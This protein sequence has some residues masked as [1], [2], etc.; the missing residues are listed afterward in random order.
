MQQL[1][2]VLVRYPLTFSACCINC[3]CP[4]AGGGFQLAVV[5]SRELANKRPPPQVTYFVTA[6]TDSWL[7]AA[8]LNALRMSAGLFSRVDLQDLADFAPEIAAYHDTLT[9][10]TADAAARKQHPNQ[11]QQQQPQPQGKDP[12]DACPLDDAA[13]AAGGG[14]GTTESERGQGSRKWET[15]P[16]FVSGG[17][18]HPYQLEGL[19]WLYHKARVKENVILADEMGLGKTIQA[20]AYLGALWQVCVC[21]CVRLG[22]RAAW[23][24]WLVGLASWL[25]WPGLAADTVKSVYG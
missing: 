5:D 13:A 25:G 21:V 4:E 7:L 1:S 17:E 6:G 8:N 11:Q 19:N 12:P 10:I 22:A 18:L 20:A 23:L 3:S 16:E 2:G 9:P 24:G 15:T 14:A